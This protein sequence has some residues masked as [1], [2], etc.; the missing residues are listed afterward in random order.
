MT[1]TLAMVVMRDTQ[2]EVFKPELFWT[3]QISIGGITATSRRFQ[4]RENVEELLQQCKEE[5]NVMIK[6]VEI[7]EKAERPPLLYDLTSLQRDANRILGY[8]AQ[9]TLDYCQSLYEEK[10]ITYPRTDSRYLTEDMQR[11]VPDLAYTAAKHYGVQEGRFRSEPIR[12]DAIFDSSKVTDHYAIIPTK[13]ISD[14]DGIT[15]SSAEKAILQ[16]I[17]VRLLCAMQEDYRY[18]ETSIKMSCGREEF[19]WKGKNVLQYGWKQIWNSFYPEKKRDE[20]H[21]D[22]IPSED[23]ILDIDSVELNEGRTSPP[24]HFTEVI[25]SLRGIWIIPK[26][27]SSA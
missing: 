4:G 26:E 15:L 7:K 12:K 27:R 6:T 17:A 5:G 8:T 1:P 23:T 19:S 13:S 21:I 2:I 20:E 3:V 14:S 22:A 10:L 25:C 9:Q 16:L 24:K 11:T 18:T